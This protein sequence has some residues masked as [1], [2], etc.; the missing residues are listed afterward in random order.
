MSC[1]PIAG[2]PRRNVAPHTVAIGIRRL[3]TK[4]ALAEQVLIYIGAFHGVE[5]EVKMLTETER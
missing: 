2:C 5:R 3:I 1:S 4:K